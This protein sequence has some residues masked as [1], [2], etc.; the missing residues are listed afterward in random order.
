MQCPPG[1]PINIGATL[2]FTKYCNKYWS[3]C[4]WCNNYLA[5][6]LQESFAYAKWWINISIYTSSPL[7]YL[8]SP[9]LF[10][11]FYHFLSVL[12]FSIIIWIHEEPL[13]RYI[14]PNNVC[15]FQST[16]NVHTIPASNFINFFDQVRG[17]LLFLYSNIA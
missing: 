16:M 9:T 12:T 1:L 4:G 7:F 15:V 13:F 14:C 3:K 17:K 5:K 2:A 11:I 10:V 8:R 6:R